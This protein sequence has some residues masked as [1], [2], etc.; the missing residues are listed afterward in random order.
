MDDITFSW[1]QLFTNDLQLVGF[2]TGLLSVLLLLFTRQKRLQYLSWPFGIINAVAYFFIFLDWQ[3]YGSTIT[4]I[5]F[6]FIT[7]LGTWVW[8]GQ[9]ITSVTVVQG[10]FAKWLFATEL[11]TSYGPWNYIFGTLMAAAV[12]YVPTFYL[13]QHYK[14]AAPTWDGLIFIFSAA[15]IWL[16]LKKYVQCWPLWIIVDII[17]IPL[18]A[19]QGNGGTALLYAVF[20]AMCFVGW[21]QWHREAERDEEISNIAA[22]LPYA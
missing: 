13:L 11:P 18:Y 3:L 9:L 20:M 7:V 2:V 6:L 14:D 12:A 10:R 15:A 21:Y 16:Q 4:Q 22:T 19:S 5:W 8:R 1:S 17:S